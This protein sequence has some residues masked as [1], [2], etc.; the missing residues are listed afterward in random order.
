MFGLEGILGLFHHSDYAE[1]NDMV[2][3]Y[4]KMLKLAE[5]LYTKDI[6]PVYHEYYEEPD[7]LPTPF[8]LVLVLEHKTTQL[9]SIFFQ[10]D[11]AQMGNMFS[12]TDML[13]AFMTPATYLPIQREESFYIL[14]QSFTD[15]KKQDKQGNENIK[16]AFTRAILMKQY[17]GDERDPTRATSHTD[18]AEL[19]LGS[20]MELL[21][22]LRKLHQAHFFL[23]ASFVKT[24]HNAEFFKKLMTYPLAAMTV[25]VL[26]NNRK[27]IL[28]KPVDNIVG[29]I[30]T[31]IF[32]ERENDLSA[33]WDVHFK[34][35]N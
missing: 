10:R 14:R 3:L 23:V 21:S 12:D 18:V 16:G 4:G 15:K 32:L 7:N 20:Y 31:I 35:T 26:K 13:T 17:Y 28:K 6:L 33:N 5:S 34:P 30:V 24:M 2:K 29:R 25:D 22:G 1:Y 27:L 11:L 9:G 19:K 8:T